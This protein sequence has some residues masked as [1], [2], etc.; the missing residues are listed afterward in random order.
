MSLVEELGAQVHSTADELPLGSAT[1][2]AE[3]LRVGLELLQ[4]VRQASV[5]E[6]GVPDLANAVEQLEE[7]LLALRTAQDSLATY[8][9]SIGLGYDAAPTADRT[10]RRS[11]APPPSPVDSD[12]PPVDTTPLGRW[13]T[14]RVDEVTGGATDGTVSD[15]DRREAATDPAELLRRVAQPVRAGDRE[16]LRA[17]LRRVAAPVGL[18]LGAVTPPVARHLATELLG[19]EPTAADLP[20]LTKRLSD[21]IRELLPEL[22]RDVLATQLARICRMPPP[23]RKPPPP[24]PE[25]DAPPPPTDA[26]PPPEP[27][28]V[29]PTDPAITGAVVVGALLHQ[30]GRDADS[31]RDAENAHG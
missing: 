16:R 5:Q 7:A 26:A 10:W 9:T 24:E 22:P 13:W 17:E 27:P 14:R 28:P 12:R 21:R 8:L 1:V 4:W 30:L 20:D 2:A 23:P 18:G 3:R 11:L 25:P 6:V 19:H 15:S 31:L 29:H